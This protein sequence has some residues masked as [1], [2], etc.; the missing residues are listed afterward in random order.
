VAVHVRGVVLPDDEV[1]DLWLDGDRVTLSAVPGAETVCTTGFVLPGLVDAHCHIGIRPGGGPIAS[2]DE[3]RELSASDRAVGVLAIRDAGSPYPYPELDDDPDVPRLAR[4]GRHLAPPKRYLRD[5]GVEVTAEELPGEARVQAAAGNGW[6]KLLGDW[7]D[8]SAGDLAP[9]WEPAVM[10]EAVA[11]A[12][13]AG[14]RV[15]THVFAE[16]SVAALV[17]A[18]V[19]SV[20]HGTGLSDEDIAEMAARGTA[21]VPTMLNVATFGG[22]AAQAVEKFPRYSQHMLALLDRHPSVVA[23]AYEAGVPI[24]VGSDAG[25]GTAHGMAVREMLRLRDLAGMSTMDVLRA[26]SW[27]AR[28]WLGFPGLVEGGLADLVVYDEDPRLDLGA[29]LS[30]RHII[31]RG[32]A[33]SGQK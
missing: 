28:E 5:I 26:G 6:V 27:G 22:I 25:G 14:A 3:A 12:H 2:T 31:L 16:E 33:V 9:A 13:A 20:E 23:K 10:A 1:R 11:A 4:A 17:R 30:P 8:R 32:K 29:L 19:D 15:A 7:I 21:L 18:G 24:Y